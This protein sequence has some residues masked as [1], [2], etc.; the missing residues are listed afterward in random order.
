MAL[1]GTGNPRDKR[2]AQ[3]FALLSDYLDGKLDPGL[4][5]ELERHLDACS[6]CR[7]F[8]ASLRRSV[9]ACRCSPVALPAPEIA[10]RVRAELLAEC[11][12]MLEGNAAKTRSRRKPRGCME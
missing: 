8:L 1:S 6:P 4:Q 5:Q 11:R 7:L 3:L 2:C 9:E 12:R 10:A